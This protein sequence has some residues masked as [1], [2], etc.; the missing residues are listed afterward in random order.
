MQTREK[1]PQA[2]AG[3]T[4]AP[5]PPFARTSMPDTEFHHTW[6]YGTMPSTDFT[7]LAHAEQHRQRPE[8]DRVGPSTA[9]ESFFVSGAHAFFCPNARAMCRF[10]GVDA[11]HEVPFWT[12]VVP[13]CANQRAHWE[14]TKV[15]RALFV[16]TQWWF[17]TAAC[18]VR[19]MSPCS[20]HFFVGFATESKS[21]SNDFMSIFFLIHCTDK[22]HMGGWKSELM[23]N[24]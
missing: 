23:P 7:T 10:A 22:Q 19:H 6:R 1:L 14:Q 11:K 15:A 16:S 12:L 13:T 4:L 18:S 20:T 9:A 5:R 8:D 17:G 2:I 3:S 21:R 24:C